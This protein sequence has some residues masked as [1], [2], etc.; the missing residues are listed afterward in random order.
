MM[1]AGFPSWMLNGAALLGA[2]MLAVSALTVLV[3][4]KD[5]SAAERGLWRVRESTLHL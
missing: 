2:Y 1:D 4:A 5:K 3:Y